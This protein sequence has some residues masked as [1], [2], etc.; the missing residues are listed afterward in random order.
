MISKFQMAAS[1]L[2]AV[3]EVIRQMGGTVYGRVRIQKTAYFLQ[4]MGMAELEGIDF[5]YHHYG[6]FSWTVAESL[7][8][9]ERCGALREEAKPLVDDRQAYAYKL[10]EDVDEKVDE[11]S[12]ASRELV[13]RLVGQVR[14]EHWRTLELASTIDFLEQ[15]EG[16]DRERAVSRALGL[17][18]ACRDHKDDALRLLDM[19][20]LPAS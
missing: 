11:V 19:L 6:P 16:L 12:P 8:D 15:R 9:G 3:T 5:F 7:L 17:K 13:A 1:C 14:D 2:S 4:R 20:K 10:G 18:P